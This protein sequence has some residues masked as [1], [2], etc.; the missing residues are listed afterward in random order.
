[1]HLGERAVMTKVKWLNYKVDE[2]AV[3]QK[4]QAMVY[5]QC[6]ENE[7]T[8][9]TLQ[10]IYLFLTRKCNLACQHCYIEGVGPARD[11]DFGLPAIQ[12]I[13]ERA[14]PHGLKKVKVSGGEPFVREDALDILA[15]LDSQNLEVVLETNGTLFQDDTLNRLSALK[16]FTVFVSLDHYDLNKHDE[17]RGLPGAYSRTVKVLKELGQ[18]EVSSVV[19]TTANRQNYSDVA[20]IADMVLGWGIKQHRTLLN[21][22]PL[23]NARGHLDNAITIEEA[24]VLIGSLI[25]SDHFK[26]GR[27]YMTL[28]PALMPLDMLKDLN[29]CGWGKNVVGILST[30]EISMCSASYD[31][32]DMIGGNIF[33]QDLV[34]VWEHGD[35]FRN[36]RDV[37]NGSVKGVCN[38]CI[39]YTTCR[40][41]C[42]M[43]SYAHYGEID[44]PYPLCQEVYNRGGFPQYALIDPNRNCHFGSEV[45]KGKRAEPLQKL[46]KL[47]SRLKL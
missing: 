34:E 3:R 31:D 45:I 44:A 26:A 6:T 43:S 8:L 9:G 19:T 39:F 46:V 11:K 24:E 40:G 37:G 41:V 15:Y 33:E 22:H 1:M 18:T 2:V 28:P 20:N 17:F 30:G 36:L 42:R 27:S 16:N 29:S 32:L 13:I 47:T 38:N 12:K 23:G 14:L 25:E 35:L 21:I 4:L 5:R 7:K 10:T